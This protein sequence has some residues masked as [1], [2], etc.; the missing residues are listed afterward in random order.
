MLLPIL[1]HPIKRINPR[2]NQVV[3]FEYIQI[4]PKSAPIHLESPPYRRH[5]PREQEIPT[6]W[7]TQTSTS[8]PFAFFS[9]TNPA[10]RLL[11]L[12]ST[13]LPFLS[14]LTLGCRQRFFRLVNPN[15]RNSSTYPSSLLLYAMS[16]FNSASAFPI[17]DMVREQQINFLG[18]GNGC[19]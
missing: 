16:A 8:S 7:N 19:W 1:Q 2:W 6:S 18:S 15:P 11:H 5:Q 13:T 14:L 17:S 4:L 12:A 3:R 10:V 9:L